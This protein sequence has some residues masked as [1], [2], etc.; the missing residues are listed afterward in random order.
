VSENLSDNVNKFCE[1]TGHKRGNKL[2]FKFL[3]TENLKRYSPLVKQN[4]PPKQKKSNKRNNFSGNKSLDKSQYK[5][6]IISK[7]WFSFRQK[8]IKERGKVCQRCYAKNI[9]LHAHH[10][11]YDRLGC[12]LP[13]D[14]LIVCI[15]CHEEIHGRKF[16]H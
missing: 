3:L 8:L 12:E 6:Y 2:A 15:P 13:E 16:K 11:T 7:K 9:P 1:L 5:D 10:L 4:K 14:I